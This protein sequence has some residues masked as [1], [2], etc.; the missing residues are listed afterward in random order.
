[1]PFPPPIFHT[2]DKAQKDEHENPSELNRPRPQIPFTGRHPMGS[3]LWIRELLPARA[4]LLRTGRGGVGQRGSGTLLHSWHGGA[5]VSRKTNK[6][7]F[8]VEKWL[9]FLL[10]GKL[11][12][13]SGVVN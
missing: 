11:Q 10:R 9:F 3:G 7:K 12:R 2:A 1:M 4:L 5:S 13:F 6:T 8:S